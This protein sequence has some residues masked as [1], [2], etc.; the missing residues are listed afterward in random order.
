MVTN[1]VSLIYFPEEYKKAELE[2]EDEE[3]EEQRLRNERSN[4]ILKIMR[5]Y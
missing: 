3:T 1:C 2:E 4:Y 5:G